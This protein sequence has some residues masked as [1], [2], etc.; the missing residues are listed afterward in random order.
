MDRKELT[1]KLCALAGDYLKGAGLELVELFY[2]RQ[3]RSAQLKILADRPTGGITIEECAKASREIG[4]ILDSSGLMDGHYIL[5]VSSPGL[6]RPLS[7]KEDFTRCMNRKV[8]FFLKESVEGV[9]EIEGNVQDVHDD[10]IYVRIEPQDK[11]VR[12][13]YSKIAKAKQK[14]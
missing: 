7:S 3:A 9:I 2:S 12:I 10:A 6:D 13:D 5:E 1:E 4:E 11:I 8:R 14:I